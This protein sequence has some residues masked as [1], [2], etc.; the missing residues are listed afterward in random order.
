MSLSGKQCLCGHRP[1]TLL[2]GA[3]PEPV[4]FGP[5]WPEVIAS[6]CSLFFISSTLHF[7]LFPRLRVAKQ[8]VDI[9]LDCQD[10]LHI[11][12]GLLVFPIEPFFSP[13]ACGF[14][15]SAPPFSGASPRQEAAS[16][17]P[18]PPGKARFL[19]HAPQGIS[20]C[21]LTLCICQ[22]QDGSLRIVP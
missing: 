19:P 7:F 15:P 18:A 5:T 11:L 22:R 8:A 6:L 3:R 1:Q 14:L 2:V 9:S 4:S 10:L 20:G 12:P 21:A 17:P 13:A 16:C